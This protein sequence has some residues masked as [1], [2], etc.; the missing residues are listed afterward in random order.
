MKR[1][2]RRHLKTNEL[3]S[4]TAQ[5][6]EA[7]EERRVQVIAGLVAV[8]VIAGAV[9]GYFTWRSRQQSRAYALLAEALVVDEARVGPAVAPGTPG[10][11]GQ[12]FPTQREK[13]QALLTKFRTAA[14][15]Y[16]STDAGV[17]ARYREATTWMALGTPKSAI[18]AYEEVI[19]RGGS[20]V[21]AE[22][23]RLGLAEAQAQSGQYDQ[24]ISTFTEL[25]QRKDGQVPVDGVLIRLGRAYLDAGKRAEAEQTFNRVI[26]EFPDSPFSSD[27]RRALEQLKRS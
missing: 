27:A 20:S 10:S 11:G 14:D 19:K 8:V 17:F 6:R 23:A 5:A 18:T 12:S 2:E 4:L 13:N 25:S 1:T 21:Y 9:G 22:M 3:A 16:P 15:A 7:Y 26:Q 24:A